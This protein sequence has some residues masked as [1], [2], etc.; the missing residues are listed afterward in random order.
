MLRTLPAQSPDRAADLVREVEGL[1]AEL[2][3]PELDIGLPL[4]QRLERALH[5]GHRSNLLR[6]T[7]I[8]DRAWGNLQPHLS[9]HQLD[10]LRLYGQLG[11]Y[12]AVA[13]FRGVDI[14]GVAR[15]LARVRS[16]LGVAT[17]A[18]ALERMREAEGIS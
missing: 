13:D 6:L 16:R 9:E 11:T 8:S 12:V 10:T 18:E 1:V 14:R 15:T 3:D 17:T 4:I 2:A 7:A 5:L